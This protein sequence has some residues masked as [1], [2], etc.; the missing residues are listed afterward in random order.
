MDT[1]LKENQRHIRLE[2]QD[3]SAVAGHSVDLG[4]RIQFHNTS[5][6]TTKTQYMDHIVKEAAEIE[7]HPNNMNKEVE[8]CLSK[9]W[10]PLNL[11]PQ[12]TSGI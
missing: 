3:K 12:E 10:K 11:L 9:S 2:H 1:R 6:L 7:L 8:I 4:H 5:L